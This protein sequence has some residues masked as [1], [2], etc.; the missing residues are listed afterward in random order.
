[1]SGQRDFRKVIANVQGRN[2]GMSHLSKAIILGRFDKDDFKLKNSLIVG[3]D[4]GLYLLL[5]R[6]DKEQ[7]KGMIQKNIVTESISKTR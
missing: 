2:L 6:L 4:G 7:Q 5:N 3:E 1:M